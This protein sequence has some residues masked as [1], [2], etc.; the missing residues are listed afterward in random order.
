MAI[1]Q[2]LA[3]R[4][5]VPTGAPP[6]PV[7]FR[8]LRSD[9]G[10][11]RAAAELLIVDPRVRGYPSLLQ[12]TRR[13]T[14]VVIIDPERDGI[15]QI[16]AALETCA[17]VAAIHVL[18]HGGPGR[19][20]LGRS[21]IDLSTLKD[22]P[23]TAARLRRLV[24]GGALHIIACAVG[25]GPRG[26]AFV[27]G[28]AATLD[29]PVSAFEGPL[30][31]GAAGGRRITAQPPARGRAATA[32]LI[33][34]EALRAHPVTLATYR[35]SSTDGGNTVNRSWGETWL[36]DGVADDDTVQFRNALSDETITLTV[37][38]GI[39]AS[40]RHTNADNLTIAGGEI[41]V[42]AGKTFLFEGGTVTLGSPITGASGHLQMDDNGT[43]TLTGTA[44]TYDQ[45]TASGGGTVIIA[46]DA[47]LGTGTVSLD[48][49]TLSVTGATT[50]DNAVALGAAHGTLSTSADVTLSGVLSGAGNLT[51]DGTGTLTLTGTNTYAGTTTISGGTLSI[52]ADANLGGGALTING[53]TLTLSGSTSVD[54]AIT[55]GASHGTLDNGANLTLT[56]VISGA[57]NLTKTGAG[58]LTL[59]ET[60]TYSGTTTVSAGTLAVDGAIGGGSVTIASGATLGGDGSVAGAVTVQSG[61]TLA[62]GGSVGSLATGNLSLASGATLDMELNGLQAGVTFD[63]IV[64]TGTVDL[65]GATLDTTFGF[66][67]ALDNC[68]IL[69][70]ND[71]T[72]AVTNTFDG[73]AE[74][75]LFNANGRTYKVS[76]VGGDGNDVSL[77]DSALVDTVTYTDAG[78]L[79]SL[80]EG[81]TNQVTLTP[82]DANFANGTLTLSMPSNSNV[83]SLR[84][85]CSETVDPGTGGVQINLPAQGNITTATVAIPSE[86]TKTVPATVNMNALTTNLTLC[87]SGAG[88]TLV[89]GNHTANTITGNGGQN[90]LSGGED[91]DILSGNVGFDVLYG[92]AGNDL[93]YGNTDQ[94]TLFGGQGGDSIY[95]GAGVD[96]VFGNNNDDTLLGNAGEDVI[97]G[98]HGFDVC[99]GGE[100]D[101][102]A[103]GGQG[104]DQISGDAGNDTIFGNRDPDRLI[105][106]VGADML[107]G[108]T[109]DDTLSG[110]D[111][112]DVLHGGQDNDLIHGNA[113]DDV[114][115]G[116]RGDDSLTA[117]AGSDVLY[118]GQ[119]DDVLSAGAGNDTLYGLFDSDTLAGGDGADV[120]VF[121]VD[122]GTNVVQD[123]QVG[124][125]EI[126]YQT[127]SAAGRTESDASTS[128]W[129]RSDDGWAMLDL[130]NG[131]TVTLVGVTLSQFWIDLP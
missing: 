128:Q 66:T 123:F 2:R 93:L 33:P 54:N 30:G 32:D 94:D 104:F 121:T 62:P 120:F 82:V 18:A 41:A 45:T 114:L 70:A 64:V 60:N 47:N 90:T 73:L 29:I 12:S 37:T 27:E 131:G 65:G 5:R 10:N 49:G 42:S 46:E 125:D 101:D 81:T 71:G 15:A 107:Y 102:R 39:T 31:Q 119:G 99:Y 16:G 38:V 72:D 63:Q 130:G 52:A 88:T 25:G 113:G 109:G 20:D 14:R 105:G 48:G 21:G 4:D 69:I 112:D 100:G 43:M 77:T 68:F 89:N 83:N 34:I 110:G 75:A 3:V 122:I 50:V 7:R 98:N 111:G 74:G 76:Y 117:G 61:A 97:Y 80:S 58:T 87:I 55:L 35:I 9:D 127:A 116:N 13:A 24:A 57:G 59:T 51:K 95:G 26:R 84:V 8:A 67:S 108:N 28:L 6:E 17:P 56:G 53:G 22:D 103:Y 118:G 19:M 91:N 79:S 78:D 85:E 92:N 23:A 124:V 96:E 11:D 126:V 106:G 1:M 115:Y 129:T 44:N 86:V 36:N 40:A